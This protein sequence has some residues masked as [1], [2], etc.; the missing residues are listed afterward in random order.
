MGPAAQEQVDRD[1][2]A[3]SDASRRPTGADS[4]P[5]GRMGEAV[6]AGARSCARKVQ[7]P[8][9]ATS[10]AAARPFEQMDGVSKLATGRATGIGPC[11]RVARAIRNKTVSTDAVR[12]DAVRAN[13]VCPD[14]VRADAVCPD[15]VGSDAV[16]SDA[17]GSDAVCSDAVCSDANCCAG[18]D[19][20]ATA[21]LAAIACRK[22]IFGGAPPQPRGRPR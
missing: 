5:D 3:L 17:V 6:D 15:A 18:A 13:A 8:E 9:A 14:A 21:G 2:Q 22:V 10:R 7:R 19:R 1:V 20:A 11:R 16:G 4:R 12:P